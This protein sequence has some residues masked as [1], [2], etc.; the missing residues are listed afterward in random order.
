MQN[1]FHN[2]LQKPR[3]WLCVCV[4]IYIHTIMQTSICVSMYM[5]MCEYMYMC[6]WV[7]GLKNLH[8][9]W[10][11]EPGVKGCLCRSWG[12]DMSKLSWRITLNPGHSGFSHTHVWERGW[13]WAHLSK[14][15]TSPPNS[16]INNTNT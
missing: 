2:S 4:C 10:D 7:Y 5:Y 8:D 6:V 9:S 16:R 14:W 1:N 15:Q 13:K 3:V 11:L 12:W